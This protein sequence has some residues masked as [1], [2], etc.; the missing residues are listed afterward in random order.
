MS[1]HVSCSF[2]SAGPALL[3]VTV[4][5]RWGRCWGRSTLDLG[6]GGSWADQSASSPAPTPVGQAPQH[7]LAPNAVASKGQSQISTFLWPR[8]EPPLL[9]AVNVEELRGCTSSLTTPHHRRQVVGQLAHAHPL[10][11]I[12]PA[13]VT[14]VSFTILPRQGGG[15]ASLWWV[16]LLTV[17]VFY[18]CDITPR[19]R[20]F[21]KE[22][23]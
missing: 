7:C 9:L 21:I 8:S 15:V 14:K 17:L 3:C 22:R 12:S 13:P 11:A 18:C 6:L 4:F 5:H 19:P 1:R 10:R 20:W 2:G 16:L 23:I